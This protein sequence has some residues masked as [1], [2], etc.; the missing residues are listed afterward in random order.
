MARSTG[1]AP[2]DRG[3]ALPLW[4][5]LLDE[6]RRRLRA[7][8]FHDAFPGEMELVAEYDVSRHTVREALRHLREEGVLDSSRG[9]G[10][11]VRRTPI[12]QP[13][14]SIYSLFRQ[15]EEQG[16]TQQSIVLAQER[17]VRPESAVALGLPDD[18]ELF[19]L[20]RIRCADGAPLAHDQV[21]LPWA[22]ASPLMEA[23]FTHAAL[24]DELATRCAVHITQGRERISA[25]VP[26]AAERTQLTVPRHEACFAIERTGRTRRSTVEHRRSLVRAGAFSLVAEWSPQGYSLNTAAGG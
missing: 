20:E 24:Y 1:P 25:V 3:S 8:A 5:Q 6:L 4:A 7:G 26:T 13:L 14:G 2:L 19:H 9:R 23:D 10:T 16:M 11:T 21:W 17:A 12:V 15:V 18:A 22:L